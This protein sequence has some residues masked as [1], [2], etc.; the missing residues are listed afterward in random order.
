MS[1]SSS[2]SQFL[3]GEITHEGRLGVIDIGSNSIRLVVYDAIKRAPLPLFNEKV[4][5]GLGKG[6]ATSGKLNPD[7]VKLAESC[8][9]RFMALVRIMDVVE[10]QIL[11]TAAVRDASDGAAFVETLERKH[12]ID[13]TVISGKKEAR[14]AAGGVC[15]SIYSPEGLAGDLGGGSIE[16]IGLEDGV[17]GEQ[18]T[19]PIGPLRL[20]DASKG[21]RDKMRKLISEA[22]DAERWLEKAHPP[23]FYAIGGSFRALAHIHMAEEKYPLDIVH[24][25]AIKNGPMRKLLK[26]IHNAS[27]QEIAKMDGAPAKRA[28]ALIPAALVLEHILDIT[29][30]MDVIFSASGIREGYLYEKLS[31]TLRAEDPLIAS[32]TDMAQQNGRPPGFAHELYDWMSPLFAG[33][34]E[35]TKRL[36]LAACILSEIAWRIH[37]DYRA[38]W[39]FFRVIQS[40]LSGMSHPERVAM[41]LALYHRYQF[42]LKHD[43]EMLGLIRDR[44]K[45]WARLVGTAA[46]LA[47]QISGGRPG[48]LDKVKLSLLKHEI[49]VS[50]GADAQDLMSDAVKKRVDGLGETF[51]AFAKSAK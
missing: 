11:A 35:A 18:A 40:T 38:E 41:A 39:S 17:I 13:I 16:L 6:L 8:I 43:W 25:Y 45:A 4:F 26:E 24:H 42:K 30:P 31:P 10:L 1:P 33:E 27:P 19:L 9:A 34:S 46:N 20:I 37:P 36:R 44:D 29:E 49:E 7:G 5:C 48:H 21:D 15:S 23:H 14:L 28:E 22:I 50:F 2:E 3:S 32:C 12:R 51:K 47:F